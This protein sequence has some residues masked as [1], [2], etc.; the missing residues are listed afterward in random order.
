ME[1]LSTT[2]WEDYELLD[3]GDSRRL[4]RYGQYLLNRPDPQAIWKPNNQSLWSNADAVFDNNWKT[5]PDF[6]DKW[7]LTYKN[8]SFWARL[9]PFKHTG[10]FPEQHLQWDFIT[11]SIENGKSKIGERLEQLEARY[12]VQRGV[13]VFLFSPGWSFLAWTIFFLLLQNA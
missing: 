2:G 11:Q 1:I 7:K 5:K 9:T 6:P 3:S 10:I 12:R 8:V 4:E 13:V